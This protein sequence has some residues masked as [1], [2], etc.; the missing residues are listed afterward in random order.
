MGPA[1]VILP[2]GSF[3]QATTAGEEAL[4]ALVLDACGS[5]RRV[6]D[7]FAG[8]GPFALPLAQSREV[9]AVDGDG[10]ALAALDRAARGTP[11]LRRVSTETRDL[12]RRPLLAPELERFDAVVM[13]PPRAGA[14]AQAKQLAGAKVAVVVSVSCDAATFARDAAIL[15]GS[16]YALERVVPL[17]QFKYSAHVEIVGVLRRE[18]ARPTRRR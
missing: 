2:P 9:H 10:A 4:S 11:G 12:F 1:Q 14:E 13:D 15:V 3:L 5:A 7:L 8:C 16:G 6:A 18:P 17:D